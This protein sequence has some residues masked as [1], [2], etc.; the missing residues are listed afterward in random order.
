[1]AKWWV[2]GFGIGIGWVFS[3]ISQ[4][5]ASGIEVSS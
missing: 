4:L 3:M 5:I 2:F 1:M